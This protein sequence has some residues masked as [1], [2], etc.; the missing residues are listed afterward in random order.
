MGDG[1]S[2]SSGTTWG[3][4][5]MTQSYNERALPTASTRV[6]ASPGPGVTCGTAQGDTAA[7]VSG[8]KRGKKWTPDIP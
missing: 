2:G 4:V 7:T 6:R 8:R 3:V 1:G 5:V